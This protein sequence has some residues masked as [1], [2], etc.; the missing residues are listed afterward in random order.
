MSVARDHRPASAPAAGRRTSAPIENISLV[1]FMTCGKSAIGRRV[2]A[3]LGWEF[4]DVDAALE[5][6]EGVPVA[7]LF[8]RSGEAEFR[9]TESRMIARA[10]DG[11]RRVVAT[12]GGA[13][14]GEENRR[15]LRQRS[16]VVWLRI[17]RS[18]VLSRLGRRGIEK[19]PLLRGADRA[20][21]ASRVARMLAE[22]EPLYRETAHWEIVVDGR[23][24]ER[25]AAEIARAFGF[26]APARRPATRSGYR[27]CCSRRCC[28]G[29]S[30]VR[31]CG[32]PSP[33]GR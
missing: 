9:A 3:L 12:G 20:E 25:I 5:E 22:R 1:G 23:N 27:S 24:A 14:L 26:D 10:L 8:E 30:L 4:F 19:R 6:S 18:G 7:E 17:S 15:L 21:L 28:S 16:R 32:S 2:A 31:S 33:R 13:V 11:S 29:W